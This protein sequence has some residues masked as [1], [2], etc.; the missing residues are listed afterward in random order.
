MGYRWVGGIV[1][2]YR[3]NGKEIYE[4]NRHPNAKRGDVATYE[5]PIVTTTIP[6]N[7]P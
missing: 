4:V 2:S 6:Q 1:E 7:D 3:F 5:T